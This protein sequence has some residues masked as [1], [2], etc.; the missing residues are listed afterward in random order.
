MPTERP[1]E[2]TMRLRVA[3][4]HRVFIP[5]VDERYLFKPDREYW[6]SPTALRNML[7]VLKRRARNRDD[8]WHVMGQLLIDRPARWEIGALYVL[9][10][11]GIMK[12]VNTSVAEGDTL[13]LNF[14]TPGSLCNYWAS[15]EEVYRLATLGDIEAHVEGLRRVGSDRGADQIE[16]WCKEIHHED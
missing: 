8:Y 6:M 7:Q 10:G 5:S 16:A 9:R 4:R 12:L 14:L 1:P 11:R 15:E 3:G 13:T 2:C